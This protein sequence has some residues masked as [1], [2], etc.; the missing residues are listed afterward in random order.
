MAQKPASRV[1]EIVRHGYNSYIDP[2]LQMLDVVGRRMA[3]DDCAMHDALNED[4]VTPLM[5]Q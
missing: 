2:E 1:S 3:R 4:L 5:R